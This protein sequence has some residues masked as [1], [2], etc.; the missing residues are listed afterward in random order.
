MKCNHKYFQTH[1]DDERTINTCWKCDD[2][3]IFCVHNIIIS[4]DHNFKVQ[5][6][7]CPSCDELDKLEKK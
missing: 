1:S 3:Q 2:R 7:R 4:Y 6:I 5:K